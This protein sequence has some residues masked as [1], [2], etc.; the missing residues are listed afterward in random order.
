MLPCSFQRG[1]QEDA[2]EYLIALLDAMHIM[3]VGGPGAKP[4]PAVAASSLIHRIFAGRIRSQVRRR[5]LPACA[6]A[7]RCCSGAGGGC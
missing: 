3:A 6:P 5:A 4:P 2:H 7:C 1:R